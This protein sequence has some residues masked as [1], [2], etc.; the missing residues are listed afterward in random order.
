[1]RTMFDQAGLELWLTEKIA[2][3]LAIAPEAID[4]TTPL[5]EYGMDSVYALSLF[6]DIED[7]LGLEVEPTLAW[8]YPTIVAIAGYLCEELAT[9]NREAS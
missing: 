5:A 1:M 3:Y 4:P 9:Q 6:G 2:M 8:D 7:E